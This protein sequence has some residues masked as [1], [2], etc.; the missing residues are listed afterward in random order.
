MANFAA[1]I[2]KGE[3]LLHNVIAQVHAHFIIYGKNLISEHQ[4]LITS[5]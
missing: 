4:S 5:E 2:H 3:C 1:T